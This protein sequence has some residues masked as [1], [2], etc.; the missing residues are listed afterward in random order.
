ME[1]WCEVLLGILCVIILL[2]CLK[3]HWLRRSAREIGEAVEEIL[4]TETNT[5]ITISS[6]D[7]WMRR[8]ADSMNRQLRVLHRERHRFMQGDR[9]LKE[10]MTN[11]SH[12]IRTPLT[13]I[14]GYLDLLEREEQSER[15][16][17]Y[18]QIIRNRSEVLKEL[19]EELFHYAVITSEES[20]AWEREDVVL[21]HVLEECLSAYYPQLKERHIEPEICMPEQEVHRQLNK[22]AL[23]RIYGNVIG[24][25]MKYSEGDLHIMLTEAGE[26]VF[27]NHASG[28]TEVQVE[29]LFE[30]FYTVEDATGSTGLGLTIARTLTEQMGGEIQLQYQDGVIRICLYF[31]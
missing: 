21:N 1:L 4:R 14:C 17:R 20:I 23:L 22:N 19:T 3:I 5:L 29:R 31:T 6:R 8:L 9:S 30:R 26:I 13:A 25:A 27:A 18:L 12:D 10:A 15:T 11:L 16:S 7:F 2:L 28:L 24:N